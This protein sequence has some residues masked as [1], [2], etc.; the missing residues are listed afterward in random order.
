MD[1]LKAPLFALIL[2]STFFSAL[3]RATARFEN[4]TLILP[5]LVIGNDIYNVNLKLIDSNPIDLTLGLLQVGPQ[6]AGVKI[7]VKRLTLLR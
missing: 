2:S 4:N 7:S 5:Y 6:S 1:L 3:A